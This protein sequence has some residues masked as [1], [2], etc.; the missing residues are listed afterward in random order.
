MTLEV[1]F[2]PTNPNNSNDYRES[3]VVVHN[4]KEILRESDGGEPEDNSYGRDWSWV[5]DAIETAYKLGWEDAN[6]QF[7]EK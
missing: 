1:K 6:K 2:E 4:G 3:L 5:S 7:G